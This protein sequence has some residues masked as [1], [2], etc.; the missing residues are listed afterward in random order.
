MPN[1]A[2][3]V[4][5]SGAALGILLTYPDPAQKSDAE[6]RRRSTNLR[7][8]SGSAS[9]QAGRTMVGF[10]GSGNYASR[11]L[12]PA[13]ARTQA[14]LKTIASGAGVSGTYA[15]KK[16][17]FAESTTDTERI[18]ADPAITTVVIATRH[19]SHARLVCRALRAGKHV[20]VEK[21]LA[22]TSE[23]LEEI[24]NIYQLLAASGQPPLLMV[25]FNRR[26]APQ[27]VRMRE[28]LA[29]LREPKNFIMTVNAGDIPAEHWT[30][31]RNA[32]GGRVI[33]EGCHFIDLLRFLAA[34]PITGYQAAGMG[35]TAGGAPCN[36][37][38]TITLTFADG[39]CGTVH[40]LANGHKS[41]PKERLEVFCGGRILQLDNFRRM[42]GFG[43][44]G[45]TK[46]N[47]WQQDK[48]NSACVAAFVKAVSDGLPSPILFDEL[49][50]VSGKTVEIAHSLEK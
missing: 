29:I 19:D 18:F 43:W 27:V 46:L 23:E 45:F 7:T 38:V 44:P 14:V 32:G 35:N 6:L 28:L 20:F 5:K 11:V 26:F 33:G 4:V 15:G 3:E 2:Y 12:I 30:Q 13:F 34:A 40:Y 49:M 25:G 22:L 10:I 8:V 24:R 50:E 9:P 47:L 39:S 41:F 1:K 16:F 17:G 42:N 37:K 21:P 36:D 48:G 31:D